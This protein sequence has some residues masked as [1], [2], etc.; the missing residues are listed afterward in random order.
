VLLTGVGYGEGVDSTLTGEGP[1]FGISLRGVQIDGSWLLFTAAYGGS[2]D[3]DFLSFMTG[4]R[5]SLG[6]R[7]GV[8][9]IVTGGTGGHTGGSPYL[10][11][12]MLLRATLPGESLR[13]DV[14]L[15]YSIET[16]DTP[17]YEPSRGLIKAG[18]E[19]RWKIV[20]NVFGLLLKG[21]GTNSKGTV[22]IGLYLGYD[23]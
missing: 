5:S 7:V 23:Q 8:E 13:L 14:L 16:S 4:R 21:N 19:L 2:I 15:G 11:Y 6:T 20:P 12:N 3:L 17:F 10:D 1:E 9:G 18:A 22:G